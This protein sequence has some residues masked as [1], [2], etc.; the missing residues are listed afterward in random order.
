V[1]PRTAAYVAYLAHWKSISVDPLLRL[2]D[3]RLAAFAD[4]TR[5][6]EMHA[7][8]IEDITID[9]S[10][11]GDVVFLFVHSHASLRAAAASLRGAQGARI[12]AVSMP[13]C[14]GDDLG[15]PPT[16]TFDDPNVLSVKRN[17]QIYRD[18]S[19]QSP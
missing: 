19:L 11:F 13:C 4:R 5:R 10:G 2:G 15:L 17:I 1:M 9:A 14:F 16:E 12:H 8:L 3:P 7:R 6:L 18:F